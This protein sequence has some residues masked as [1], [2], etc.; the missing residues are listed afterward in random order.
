MAK[1]G[2]LL[3]RLTVKSNFYDYSIIQVTEVHKGD[4]TCFFVKIEDKAF[5][6]TIKVIG[7]EWSLVEEIIKQ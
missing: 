1:K 2:R 4:A 6:K 5:V 7:E 3:F